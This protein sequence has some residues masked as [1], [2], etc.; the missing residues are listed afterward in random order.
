MGK[1]AEAGKAGSPVYVFP[2]AFDELLER[3]LRQLAFPDEECVIQCVRVRGIGEVISL[4]TSYVKELALFNAM[5]DLVGADTGSDQG[6]ADLI[7]RHILDSL[8]PWKKM[9][10]ELSVRQAN[11][12]DGNIFGGRCAETKST[13]VAD[14]GSG[15]GF[16]GIPLA[17]IFPDL[18]FTLIERMSK[19]C[20]F[21]ENCRAILN[22][23]NVSVLNSE[24]EHAPKGAYDLVVF[25][26]FR[27]LDHAMVSTLLSMIREGGKLAAYKAKKEKIAEEMAAIKD[28][29]YGW[30][31]TGL[32]V[33]F[34]EHE[35]RNL[36]FISV[37]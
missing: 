35:E 29:V 6:K 37:G 19:R 10:E 36:V 24:V 13:E 30:E 18:H 1:K 21:L 31:V 17:I 9:V 26:A 32:H 14:A 12:A 20:S 5:F 15:A 4:V 28:I 16:P 8:A 2:Y 11:S 33:P 27:P 25:R 3:G 34:L 7:V 23:K 22:L